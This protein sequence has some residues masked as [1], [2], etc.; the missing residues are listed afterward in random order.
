VKIDEV[1]VVFWVKWMMFSDK[2]GRIWFARRLI[3]GLSVGQDIFLQT[4][5]KF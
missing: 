2:S 4:R 3:S 5:G 1:E